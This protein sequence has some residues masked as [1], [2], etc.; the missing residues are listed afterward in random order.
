[1]SSHRRVVASTSRFSRSSS[2]DAWLH[3]DGVTGDSEAI[4]PTF[5]YLLSLVIGLGRLIRTS[6]SHR[7][8][9][10]TR[11][12]DEQTHARTHR[13]G[14]ASTGGAPAA[15]AACA[16]APASNGGTAAAAPASFFTSERRV[17]PGGAARAAV[18]FRK[19]RV[20][21]STVSSCW[22]GGSPDRAVVAGSGAVGRRRGQLC[23]Y[24]D[25]GIGLV[26]ASVPR[27]VARLALLFLNEHGPGPH[28]VEGDGGRGH[29]AEDDE[30]DEPCLKPRGRPAACHGWSLLCDCDGSG[31]G[32]IVP[33]RDGRGEEHT[34]T[35]AHTHTHTTTGEID[36]VAAPG[37]DQVR[38]RQR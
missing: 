12:K 31:M 27:C 38:P 14:R 20:A 15:R 7:A 18:C 13:P 19:P 29:C 25:V 8:W 17:E 28:H 26:K 3:R 16:A 4:L 1:M 11:T 10:P 32:G 21:L 24:V 6:T 9:Q 33:F 35:H 37:S 5:A 22:V 30:Q 36:C 2:A 23:V 34:Q